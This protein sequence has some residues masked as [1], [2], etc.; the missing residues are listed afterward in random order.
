[1]KT[2]IKT[3]LISAILV[4]ILMLLPAI[5]KAQNISTNTGRTNSTT[6][7]INNNSYDAMKK[8]RELINEG[9]Y[10]SA[11]NRSIT[12][13]RGIENDTRSGIEKSALFNEAYNCLC[14]S[15]T[16]LGKVDYAMGSCNKSL[17]LTPH[18]WESLKARATLHFLTKD[19]PKSLTDF[20]SALE[21]SPNDEIAAVLRQ[22]ISVVQSKIN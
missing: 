15:S 5:A 11:A 1:M 8:I 4:S 12:F 13:I 19:F 6:Q 7:E 16:A 9:N 22:N 17:Q 14:V 20:Q 10:E 18:H 21:N 2:V 3:N